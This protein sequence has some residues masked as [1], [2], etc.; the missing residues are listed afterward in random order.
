M[1][2]TGI[3]YPSTFTQRRSELHSPL[4]C[5]GSYNCSKYHS[6]GHVYHPPGLTRSCSYVI[7]PQLHRHIGAVESFVNYPPTEY[8]APTS[9][10]SLDRTGRK[11]DFESRRHV[12]CHVRLPYVIRSSVHIRKRIG[13]P[14]RGAWEAQPQALCI[15]EV[16]NSSPKVVISDWNYIN[17][18][19]FEKSM[20]WRLGFM[21][22]YASDLQK[23]YTSFLHDYASR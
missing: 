16:R 23:I 7:T 20:K 8:S 14:L 22:R 15:S 18:Y 19:H 6:P 2:I 12:D 3:S 13:P 17:N 4:R 10:S 11:T 9:C 1:Q 21:F 5:G